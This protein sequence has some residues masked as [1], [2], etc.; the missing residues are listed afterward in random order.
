MK[1]FSSFLFMLTAL[2]KLLPSFVL[3]VKNN[4]LSC[5]PL[6]SVKDAYTFS[7]KAVAN[8]WPEFRKCV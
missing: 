2:V 3:L 5:Q 4:S 7:P 6:P 8:P 1:E